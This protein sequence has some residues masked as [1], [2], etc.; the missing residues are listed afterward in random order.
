MRQW[1]C[2][3]AWSGKICLTKWPGGKIDM[4]KSWSPR[5][6]RS[7]QME[8]QRT[9]DRTFSMRLEVRKMACVDPAVVSKGSGKAER[10]GGR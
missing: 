10:E 5:G 6:E 3:I 9:W 7:R 1:Q 8:Q 2:K 4:I